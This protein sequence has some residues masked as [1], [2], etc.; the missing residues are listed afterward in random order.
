MRGR[1]TRNEPEHNSI[2]TCTDILKCMMAEENR[3]TTL[4]DDT[5]TC[6]YILKC[7]MAEEIRY[8]TLDDDHIGALSICVIYGWPSTRAKGQKKK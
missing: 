3:Y 8:T 6:T 5:E 2:E 1:N 7:M 4:E